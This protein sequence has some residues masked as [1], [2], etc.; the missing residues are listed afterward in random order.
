[1]DAPGGD[2][3]EVLVGYGLLGPDGVGSDFQP[4]EAI[5]A[6]LEGEGPVHGVYDQLFGVGAVLH[7][8]VALL[9]EVGEDAIPGVK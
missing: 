2:A 3:W 8:L 9:H 6:A 4:E 5:D 7:E 1:M